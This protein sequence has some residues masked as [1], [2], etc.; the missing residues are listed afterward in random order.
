MVYLLHFSSKY[1]AGI[2]LG[3]SSKLQDFQTG[4]GQGLCFPWE[5]ATR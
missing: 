5:N 3:D 2:F 4:H 1:A